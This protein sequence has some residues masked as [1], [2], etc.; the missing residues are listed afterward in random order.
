MPEF[1]RYVRRIDHVLPSTGEATRVP[2]F[3]RADARRVHLPLVQ[4]S[5]RSAVRE[6]PRPGLFVFV[7]TDGIGHVGRLW[8]AATDVPR[9]GLVGRHDRVDLQLGI[10][11]EL[12]LRQ[13]L[14][15]VR[16]RAGRVCFTVLDLDTP[17]GLLSG[18]DTPVHLLESDGLL[19]FRT[20]SLSFFCVPTGPGCDVP[21]SLDEAWERFDAAPGRREATWQ[22]RLLR[23]REHSPAG[24][25]TLSGDGPAQAWPVGE[26]ALARGVLVGRST[27]CG[28]RVDDSRVSRVHAVLLTLD[29]V[30]HIIDACSTNGLWCGDEAVRCQPVRDGDVFEFGDC[31]LQWSAS[32]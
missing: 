25:L 30:P 31:T 27:R 20:G 10:D 21:E 24:L 9:A 17:N 18:A 15:V 11:D 23:R 5:L 32:Q 16:R 28:V 4:R 2:N 12:S 26:A 29:G 14:F 19:S 1:T 6:Q 7:A 3:P 13:V 8:L 22:H